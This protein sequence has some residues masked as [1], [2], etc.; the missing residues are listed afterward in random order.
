M[1]VYEHEEQCTLYGADCGRRLWTLV[2][3]PPLPAF[4]LETDPFSGALSLGWDKVEKRI[5][6]QGGTITVEGSTL[7]CAIHLGWGEFPPS[8]SGRLF[9]EG[10]ALTRHSYYEFNVKF[11]LKLGTFGTLSEG[12]EHHAGG[13]VASLLTHKLRDVCLSFPR[14]GRCLW[15]DRATLERVSPY[16]QVLF[17]SGFLEVTESTPVAKDRPQEERTS[18]TTPPYEYDDSD[19]ETD[20]AT[21]DL[22]KQSAGSD[23]PSFHTVT[24]TQH[25]YETYLALLCWI[26]TGTVAFAPLR[27]SFVYPVNP[28]MPMQ[29]IPSRSDAIF[30]SFDVEAPSGPIFVSPKSIYRL[31][32]FLELEGDLPDLALANF[33]SQLTVENVIHE[34]Y[35]DVASKYPEIRDAALEFAVKNWK[36]VVG[37]QAYKEVMLRGEQGELDGLTGILLSDRLMKEWAK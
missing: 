29:P 22:S 14:S 11:K 34:A 12:F 32:H 2:V 25:T 17:A 20:A 35:T 3:P 33:R 30:G 19:V 31:A 1:P 16:Y 15:V 24:I 27:S 5:E 21:K 23:S 18:D 28:P 26:G 7:D 36:K 8:S 37:T 10:P 6:V 4:C 9:F 13:F